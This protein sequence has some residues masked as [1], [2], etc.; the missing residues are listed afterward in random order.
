M[1]LV[2]DTS[3]KDLDIGLFDEDGVMLSEFHHSPSFNERGVHDGLLASQTERLLREM[4]KTVRDITRVGFINGP[5]SFTGLRIGLAFAKGLA[6]GSSVKLVPVTIHQALFD[7]YTSIFLQE[8]P[9][10]IVSQGYEPGSV[11]YAP[12]DDPENVTLRKVSD[13]ARSR[14]SMILGVP[15]L[16]A[17]FETMGLRY[18]PVILS[19]PLVAKIVL[20]ATPVEN[21]ADLEPFY[22][23]DFKPHPASMK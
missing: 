21:I 11:Y 14:G 8:L 13:I 12:S 3:G 1:I 5:G 6:F 23:T 4:D 9:T 19:L 10:G 15:E 17:E 20:E 22:G 2:F 16:Q 18:F 7:F